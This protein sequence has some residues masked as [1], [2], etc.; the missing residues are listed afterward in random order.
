MNQIQNQNVQNKVVD[1]FEMKFETSLNEN[2]FSHK[3]FK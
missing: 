1:K 2:I 3:M